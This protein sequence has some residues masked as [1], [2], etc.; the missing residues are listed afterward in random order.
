MS[1]YQ[2]F[3]KKGLTEMRRWDAG[4]DMAGVSISEADRDNG[5]PKEGDMVARN[6]IDHTDRWLVAEAFFNKNYEAA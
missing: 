1:E 4:L 2:L 6:P 3:R 5:S